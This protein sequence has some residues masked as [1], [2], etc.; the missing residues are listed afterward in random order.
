M[1]AKKKVTSIIC[2]ISLILAITAGVLLSVD[3]QPINTYGGDSVRLSNTEVTINAQTSTK[4][5]EIPDGA[6]EI[7]DVEELKDF[8][9]GSDTYGYLA[10]DIADTLDWTGIGARQI[11]A[12]GRTLDGN[13]HS[14]TLADTDGS[15]KLEGYAGDFTDPLDTNNATI[16]SFAKKRNY[17]MLVDYNL[18]TIKNV[19]FIYNS[20]TQTLQNSDLDGSSGDKTMYANYVGIVCG[21][22]SGTIEHCDLTVSGAFTYKYQNGKIGDGSNG[23]HSRYNTFWGG[24][25]GRNGGTISNITANYTNFT[26]D[27]YTK[28]QNTTNRSGLDQIATDAYSCAGGISGNNALGKASVSEII[29]TGNNINFK[30]TADGTKG[31]L[32]SSPSV[33]KFFGLVVCSNSAYSH[34]AGATQDEQGKVDNIIVDATLGNNCSHSMDNKVSRNG[35][36]AC[37][38]STNVTILTTSDTTVDNQHIDYQ[39]D[40]CNCGVSGNTGQHKVNYGNLIHT[41]DYSNVTVGFDEDNNQVIKVTPKENSILGEFTFQKYEDKGTV[42]DGSL[43]PGIPDTAT[44]N[45]VANN[46]TTYLYNQVNIRD[47]EY[48]FKIRPYQAIANKYWEIGAYSYEIAELD[49]T[50]EQEAYVYTYTGKDFLTDQLSFTSKSNKSGIANP[51]GFKAVTSEGETI[52]SGRLPGTYTFTLQEKEAGLAYVD[53]ANRVVAY[54]EETPTEYSF[55]V[56]NAQVIDI[57]DEYLAP[58]WMDARHDFEFWLENGIEGAANGYV[59]EVNG[60][61]PTQVDNLT[62]LNNVDTS[63]AGRT[64]TIYL[65]SDGVQVTDTYTY[66]VL[67]DLTDPTV[68]I[69]DIEHNEA[70]KYYFHNKI[71]IKATDKASG[72][73]S[74]K[75]YSDGVEKI[76][77][78]NPAEST[79]ENKY[80]VEANI[81][82]TYTVKFSETGNNVI[83]VVDN[84]GHSSEIPVNILIDNTTPTIN[85]DAYYYKMDDV[86]GSNDGDGNPIQG[87]VKKQYNYDASGIG[88]KV[89]SAVYFDVTAEFGESGGEIRYRLEDGGTWRVLATGGV[90]TLTATLIVKTNGAKVSFNA[91]SNTY[92]HADGETAETGYKLSRVGTLWK[93]GLVNKITVNIRLEEVDITFDD[94]VITNATKTFDGTAD[95]DLNNISVRDDFE[96]DKGVTGVKITSVKYADVNAGEDIELIIDVTCEDDTKII[97]NKIEGAVGS[98]TKKAISVVVDS[99]NKYYEYAL[100]TLTYQPV[101]DMIGG[102]E[103]EIPLCVVKGEGNEELPYELL[104]QSE[105]YV[106]TVVE[107]TVLNNYEIT[108]ITTG[109]LRIDLAPVDRLVYEKGAF[110]GLDTKNIADRNLEIGFIRADGKYEKLDVKFYGLDIYYDSNFNQINNGYAKEYK[111]ITKA[112]AGFYKVII[113]LPDRDSNGDLF[114]NMYQMSDDLFINDT[115]NKDKQRYNFMIKIIDASIFDVEEKEEEPAEQEPVKDSEEQQR[116][117]APVV[118]NSA[119]AQVGIYEDGSAN[120]DS[121]DTTIE[122]VQQ[123]KDYIAMISIFCAVAILMAFAFGV[124]KAII[125]R[126]RR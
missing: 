109:L 43:E 76:D 2:I 35:V 15:G 92:N 51:A 18:G 95:F 122:S 3:A 72:V 81:D 87:L 73:A 125:K 101:A 9:T 41:G 50:V 114:A 54:P 16:A 38:R 46:D 67:I 65:T 14:I 62:M 21:T 107:G 78:M 79:E 64:Y 89:D 42:T 93:D 99:K 44:Y 108:N 123:K 61:S 121:T 45:D 85:V 91:V 52:T 34:G 94:I 124:G 37:G 58:N 77:I 6:T 20:S 27:V 83:K 111:D 10:N 29:I 126:I 68:E 115:V 70:G 56:V 66:K 104:P 82:G 8:I 103:E 69:T 80:S 88:E 117:Q 96:S 98:I 113:S 84:A 17:G 97:V 119:N 1:A 22:N 118:N 110:T 23:R 25:A 47:D 12:E 102:F 120:T 59:Y 11:F 33:F 7:T 26:I 31:Y 75:M 60:S 53:T 116:Q 63:S 48:V 86:E 57:E 4:S 39:T 112:P 106:I 5:G 100:P 19:K 30:M 49:N 40:N 13:G 105:G 90:G 28:A 55:Q 74:I 36:V 32:G 24:I 71:T